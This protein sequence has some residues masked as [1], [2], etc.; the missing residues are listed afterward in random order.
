MKQN[1]LRVNGCD[2]NLDA[3]ATM[4]FNG[5]KKEYEHSYCIGKKDDELKKTFD[6]LQDAIKAL[7]KN[8]T[9]GNTK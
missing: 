1:W 6:T 3:V 8:Q 4:D 2:F 9:S 5:F 7:P